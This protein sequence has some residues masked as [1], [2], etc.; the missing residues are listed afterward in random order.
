[1]Y[2]V[3]STYAQER[4]NPGEFNRRQSGGEIPHCATR[5]TKGVRRKKPGRLV[6]NEVEVG[7][8]RGVHL[9]VIDGHGCPVPSQEEQLARE[10]DYLVGLGY[11][12]GDVFGEVGVES[13]GVFFCEEAGDGFLHLL[14]RGAF[15]VSGGGPLHQV[16]E[17]LFP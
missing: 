1:M 9:R 3:N 13:V 7:A 10:G 4:A 17:I 16:L 5:R 6:R 12:G 15:G 2:L 14:K 11:I 8:G